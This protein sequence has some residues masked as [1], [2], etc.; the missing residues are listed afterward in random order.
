MIEYD[1]YCGHHEDHKYFLN[2]GLVNLLDEN[3]IPS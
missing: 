3:V 2:E 1:R